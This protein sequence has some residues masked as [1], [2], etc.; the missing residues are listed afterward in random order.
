MIRARAPTR[1][2]FGGGGSDVPPYCW[3]HGGRVVSTTVDR[4]AH[5]ALDPGGDEICL[6]SVDFSVAA[7]FD[8]GRLAY[9]GD[10][11]DLLKA[12]VNQF[13]ISEGFELTVAADL[14]PGAGMGG[15]SAVAVAVLRC[16][17]TFVGR[18][19]STDGLARLAYH[20]EREDLGDSGGY[21]DQYAAAFGGMN[22]I[23]FVAGEEQTV[24]EPL[25]LPPET[26]RGLERR[27]LLYYTGQTHD[28]G[29]IHDEL[30]EQYR[31][32]PADQRERRDRLKQ[33]ATRM[34]TALQAG[35]LDRFG[36]LLHEGWTV[37]KSL[38]ARI[39]NPV[40]DGVYETAR[41]NGA[42]GGK[43]LGAGGGGHVLLFAEPGR[44]LDVA[45]ALADHDVRR[46]PF[47][48]ENA[49]VE[50]TRS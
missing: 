10:E 37:K 24:L 23:R 26:R 20:A 32:E 45:Y 12:A 46:V 19:L 17:A 14:P 25:D 38:S 34:T 21:Q 27:S 29:E 1:V 36:T 4:Y 33:V 42:I 22:T 43:L 11:L 35:D 15:S 3:E 49:G 18:D 16:L 2:S 13:E 48:F 39:T 47:S 5:A 40:V 41:A 6:R 31:E 28:S 8:P 50:V 30:D 9:T 7:S 44:S